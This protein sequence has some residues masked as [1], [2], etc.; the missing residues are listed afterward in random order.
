[1]KFKAISILLAS[2][3]LLSAQNYSKEYTQCMKNSGG[4]TLEMRLCNGD[5]VARQ[6]KML[7]K[8]YKQSM[9]VLDKEKKEELK[10]VQRLWM[11]YRDVKCGFL[12]GLTGGTMDMIMS[13]DCVLEMTAGRAGELKSIGTMF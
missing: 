5:E 1:M 4:V 2:V 6:D 9:K 10:K 11:K 13:G 3:T 12:G 8:N 7:N